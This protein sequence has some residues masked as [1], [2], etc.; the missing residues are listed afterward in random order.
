MSQV[1]ELRTPSVVVLLLDNR[2]VATFSDYSGVVAYIHRTHSYSFSHALQYE[3][4]SVEVISPE[5]LG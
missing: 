2:P 1:A 5:Q 4:Y 3:G